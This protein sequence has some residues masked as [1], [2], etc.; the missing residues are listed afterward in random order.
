MGSIYQSIHPQTFRSVDAC[1]QG[2]SIGVKIEQHFVVPVS[3][4]PESESGSKIARQDTVAT[5]S[6]PED[7]QETLLTGQTSASSTHWI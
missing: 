1:I 5:N 6:D 4:T 7:Y 2:D 3:T